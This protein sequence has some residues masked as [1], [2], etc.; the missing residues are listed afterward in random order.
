MIDRWIRDVVPRADPDV[1]VWGISPSFFRPGNDDP[2]ACGPITEAW[3][4]AAELRERVFEDVPDAEGLSSTQLLFGDP[5]PVDP[6]YVSALHDNYRRNFTEDGGRTRW[7]RRSEEDIA[8]ARDALANAMETYFVCQ[9]RLDQYAATVEWLTEQG[10]DVVLV[11]MP[12]SDF[13]ATAFP[14]GR[15]QI[16]ELMDPIA[17]V[18]LDAGAVLYLDL[19]ET[20][21]DNR[22]RDLRH[23]DR[24][25]AERFTTRIANEL[26]KRGF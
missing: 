26:A 3:V 20:L 9:P 15:E 22:F 10:I 4:A 12:V 17:Q 2:E 25:G 6:P 24:R 7:P 5:I 13:Q 18:G 11:S 21:G 19:S 16:V 14:G 23:V 1:V 8:T